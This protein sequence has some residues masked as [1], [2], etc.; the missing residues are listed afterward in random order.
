MS[1]LGTIE[2]DAGIV[3]NAIQSALPLIEKYLPAADVLGPDVQLAVTAAEGLM[4]LLN[5]IPTGLISTADQAALVARIQTLGG[6]AAFQGPE[7]Q[8]R[9]T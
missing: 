8:P 4:S 6:P 2:L 5:A 1:T 9:S 3:L 7:W